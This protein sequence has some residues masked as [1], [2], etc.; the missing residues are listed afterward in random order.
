MLKWIVKLI[1]NENIVGAHSRAK[2]NSRLR[3]LALCPAA[4][5]RR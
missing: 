2:T 1:E 5:A 4:Q 3:W